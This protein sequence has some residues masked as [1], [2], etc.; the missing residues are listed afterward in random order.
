MQERGSEI[1]I[2]CEKPENAGAVYLNKRDRKELEQWYFSS[3]SQ[4]K[5]LDLRD[6]GIERIGS[7]AFVHL[8]EVWYLNLNKNF[9]EKIRQ[10]M[11]S[12]LRSLRILKLADNLISSIQPESFV[13][14]DGLK[15]IILR[16]N[17][18]SRLRPGTFKGARH[19]SLLDLSDNMLVS[20]NEDAMDPQLVHDITWG[21]EEQLRLNLYDNEIQCKGT[22]MC[23]IKRGSE[24]NMGVELVN[25]DVTCDGVSGQ[26]LL[27]YLDSAPC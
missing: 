18:L 17:M 25:N 9:L 22:K 6:L 26:N 10:G 13:A 4:C 19:L 14:M 20:L 27:E 16:N 21:N 23:W 12:G 15:E 11:M 3:F 8:E 24:N 5:K 2:E 1:L 7:G